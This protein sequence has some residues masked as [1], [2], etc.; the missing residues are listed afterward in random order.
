MKRT[1]ALF[2]RRQTWHP[3]RHEAGKEPLE[4]PKR[5]RIVRSLIINPKR[6]LE[7]DGVLEIYMPGFGTDESGNLQAA[8]SVEFEDGEL[9]LSWITE[10][11]AYEEATL[12]RDKDRRA[13]AAQ[14]DR[15]SEVKSVVKPNSL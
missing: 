5:K 4:L 7:E 15:N 9:R 13:Q 10:D 8:V 2:S 11:G 6:F 3:S 12:P 1:T 14:L